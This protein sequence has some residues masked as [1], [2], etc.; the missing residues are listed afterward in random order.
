MITRH[1][2]HAL[3]LPAPAAHADVGHHWAEHLWSLCLAGVSL[4]TP[5]DVWQS[6]S[7]APAVVIPLLLLLL[8][9]L[10]GYRALFRRSAPA[11]AQ[12][13][14]RCRTW[15]AAGWLLLAVCLMSP[16]CR[17]SAT[18]VAAHMVQL[19]LLVAVAPA[20]LDLGRTGAVLT[21]AVPRPWLARSAASA[22]HALSPPLGLLTFGYGALIWLWHAPAV[23]TVI[24]TSAGWHWLAFATLIWL[25]T[26]FWQGIVGAHRHRPAAAVGAL[27]TTLIHTGL[28]GALL[29]FSPQALYPV[30]ADGARAWSLQPLHDQQLAGLI[31]WVGGGA[32][33]LLAAL[34][35]CASWLNA[36]S[37]ERSPDRDSVL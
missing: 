3:M 26:L 29:T 6:W 4:T 14:R 35:L 23:Y 18:L 22:R 25:S 24:Q 9:Y 30:L 21:A 28:L 27:L 11:T 7:L 19:M 37:W 15:F 8:A 36:M 16:L 10:R 1:L 34:L 20:L 12:E 31:M 33:Y 13:L 17:L 2:T 32:L 5:D